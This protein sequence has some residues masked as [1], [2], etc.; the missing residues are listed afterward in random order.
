MSKVELAK[1]F[2]ADFETYTDTDFTSVWLWGVHGCANEKPDWGK[3]IHSFFKYLYRNPGIYWFHNLGFDGQFILHHLLTSD[4]TWVERPKKPKEFTTL[5]NADGKFYQI[6]LVLRNFSHITFKD[7]YKKFPM[8]IADMSK[9]FKMDVTKGEMEYRSRFDDGPITADELDYLYRDVGILKHA[10]V[11]MLNEGGVALTIGS[12]SLKSFKR[13]IGNAYDSLFPALDDE[14]DQ[15][16]R[17]AYR[18]GYTHVPEEKRQIIWTNGNVF[19]VNSLYPY[20]MVNKPMPYGEPVGFDGRATIPTGYVGILS[21]TFTA[22]IRDGYLPIIQVNGHSIFGVNEYVTWIN[23]PITMSFTGDE[24]E[25]VNEHYDVQVFSWNGGMVFQSSTHIFEEYVN[26]WMEI[27]E[28]SEGGRRTL[29]K[30]HMNALYGKF[31]TR[32]TVVSKV[33]FLEDDVVNFRLTEPDKRLPVY[34]AVAVFTTA[35]ARE[36]TIRAA[37]S[38]YDQFLYCDTDSLHLVGDYPS[39]LDVHPTRLGAWK[40]EYAF[41]EGIYLRQKAYMDV[42]TEGEK[43]AR[44]SGLPRHISQLCEF[45]HFINGHVFDG[46]MDDGTFNEKFCKLRPKRIPGGISLVPTPFN[47]IP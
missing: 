27:K 5:I 41:S 40:H 38:H 22:Q 26:H 14:T 9:Q 17:D 39:D 30:L 6:E 36:H 45:D 1:H 2:A 31:G 20:I 10:L 43:V 19:D 4:W 11:D 44:V 32:T 15:V 12:D 18:G 13:G 47:L 23:D 46:V 24:W 29:A 42:T 37:Q 21:V 33:P 8:S 3:D 25:L 7:S 35:F 16:I 34:T 28:T